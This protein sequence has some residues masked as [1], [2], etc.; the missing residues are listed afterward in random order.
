MLKNNCIACSFADS[1]LKDLPEHTCTKRNKSVPNLPKETPKGLLHIINILHANKIPF[2]TEYRFDTVRRFKFDIAIL[3][4]QLA[5]EYEGLCSEKSR[6]TTLTGYTK[7]TEKYN[8][9]TCQQWK[10][11]RYTTMNYKYIYNDL[12]KLNIISPF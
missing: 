4:Y 12:V 9:A 6:H 11:L 2:K 5:I 10:V 1:K 3:H 8:L 7:D